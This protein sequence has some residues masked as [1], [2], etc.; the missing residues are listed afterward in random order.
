MPTYASPTVEIIMAEYHARHPS[1][2][3]ST[4]S[5]TPPLRYPG[6]D[7]LALLRSVPAGRRH[8]LAVLGSALARRSPV[9][10]SLDFALRLTMAL[11][12]TG[13]VRA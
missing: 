4:P 5:A 2:A 1:H 6:D 3:S 10:P 7:A 13:R 11:R 9:A 8:E 12:Q